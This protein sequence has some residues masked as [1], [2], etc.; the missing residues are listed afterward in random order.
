MPNVEHTAR[1]NSS[2]LLVGHDFVYQFDE[3]VQIEQRQIVIQGKELLVRQ[4]VGQEV[5]V[6]V[7]EINR[8]LLGL[9]LQFGV[10]L[11]LIVRNVLSYE[12]LDAGFHLFSGF[13]SLLVERF[14]LFKVFVQICSFSLCIE[15][16]GRILRGLLVVVA[17]ALRLS[18]LRHFVLE[19]ACRLVFRINVQNVLH[20]VACHIVMARIVLIL[21]Q[22]DKVSK[23]LGKVNAAC[24][25]SLCIAVNA[26]GHFGAF[27]QFVEQSRVGYLLHVEVKAVFGFIIVNKTVAAFRVIVS[28]ASFSS[29]VRC[30]LSVVN[31][32]VVGVIL[33]IVVDSIF[34]VAEVAFTVKSRVNSLQFVQIYVSYHF[35]FTY[36]SE[37]FID[38]R[39]VNGSFVITVKGCFLIL[40]F[41]FFGF[42]IVFTERQQGSWHMVGCLPCGSLRCERG[43]ISCSNAANLSVGLTQNDKLVGHIFNVSGEYPF[44]TCD[45]NA[46]TGS[47]ISFDIIQHNNCILIK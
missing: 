36:S 13:D 7:Q 26:V 23:R 38:E 15:R 25:K 2:H 1:S 31:R 29:Y 35:G 11:L 19:V 22:I 17:V 43:D 32:C 39:V 16:V 18:G 34:F 46:I 12:V 10:S 45:F 3:L 47:V 41:V 30:A 44:R 8:F 27:M 5:A 33:S 24:H 28:D 20:E 21:C 14:G 9:L 4:G 37:R 40:H 6:A 42:C